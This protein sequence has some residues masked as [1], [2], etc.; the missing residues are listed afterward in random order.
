MQPHHADFYRHRGPVID[1]QPHPSG[2]AAE[3]LLVGEIHVLD[4]GQGN[5]RGRGR[6]AGCQL[7]FEQGEILVQYCDAADKSGLQFIFWLNRNVEYHLIIQIALAD[8]AEVV[9][10]EGI[11][12]GRPDQRVTDKG[13]IVVVEIRKPLQGRGVCFVRIQILGHTPRLDHFAQPL[14]PFP[15]NFRGQFADHD[16]AFFVFQNSPG[17]GLCLIA[18]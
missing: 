4:Q 7:Y 16:D 3:L 8:Q 18:G 12:M 15:V 14:L 11:G 17:I 9:V 10:L 13:D 2:K 5:G 6:P 1:R